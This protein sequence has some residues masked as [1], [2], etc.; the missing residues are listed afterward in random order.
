[1]AF[2]L[3]PTTAT[4]VAALRATG[5]PELVE[6]C[7]VI[8]GIVRDGQALD[9]MINTSLPAYIVLM[10]LRLA[11]EHERVVAFQNR[12][13]AV[14]LLVRAAV[15]FNNAITNNGTVGPIVLTAMNNWL[16][17]AQALRN[18]IAAGG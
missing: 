8:D 9:T 2:G 13:D 6:L 3:D 17:D 12:S 16:T 7:D 10:G 18:Q 1:M 14:N 15:L 4:R 5:T 11:H